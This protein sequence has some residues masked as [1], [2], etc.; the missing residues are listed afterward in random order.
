MTK[1]LFVRVLIFLISNN[2]AF[3]KDTIKDLFFIQDILIKKEKYSE[4]LNNAS[5]EGIIEIEHN[6]PYIK[7]RSS[8]L[9]C[10]EKLCKL[11]G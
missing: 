4:V 10:V 2:Y 7:D 8:C 1:K 11:L 9:I 3:A 5:L 6:G